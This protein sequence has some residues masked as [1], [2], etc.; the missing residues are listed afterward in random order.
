M[1]EKKKDAEKKPKKKDAEKKPQVPSRK[2]KI[3]SGARRARGKVREARL[4]ARRARRVKVLGKN[5]PITDQR[6]RLRRED[7]DVAGRREL[8]IEQEK[9][10]RELARKAHEM[11]EEAESLGL[12]A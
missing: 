4:A 3:S 8:R 11:K 5:E 1:A 9:T 7:L 2:R 10:R 12:T 6:R